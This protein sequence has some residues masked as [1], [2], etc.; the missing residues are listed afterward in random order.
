MK[1]IITLTVG[2]L[3]SFYS[4]CAL[5]GTAT[6]SK[7]QQNIQSALK[8]QKSMQLNEKQDLVIVYGGQDISRQSG[9]FAG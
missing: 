8:S 9:V 5:P 1:K 6:A 3:I 7:I 4:M 2:S